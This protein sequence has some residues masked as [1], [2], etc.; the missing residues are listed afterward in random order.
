MLLCFPIPV[1]LFA[2]FAVFL[3]AT[4]VTT[5]VAL[6]PDATLINATFTVPIGLHVF[7][8]CSHVRLDKGCVTYARSTRRSPGEKGG[9]RQEIGF[10][11][12]SRRGGVRVLPVSP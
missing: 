10:L 11:L 8:V 1:F 9:N 6:R 3:R 2:V 4:V 12:L 5:C 7:P